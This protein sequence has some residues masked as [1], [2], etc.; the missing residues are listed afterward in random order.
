HPRYQ[1]R[2]LSRSVFL[3]VAG[4]AVAVLPVLFSPLRRMRR[5]PRSMDQ[6]AGQERDPAESAGNVGSL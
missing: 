4:Q 5:L 3:A 2:G 6:H 1:S